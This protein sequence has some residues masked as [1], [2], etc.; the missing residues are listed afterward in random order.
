MRDLVIGIDASTTAVKAIAF[1]RTGQ[2]LAECRA[3]YPMHMPHPGHYEQNPQDWWQS[4]CAALKDL[5]AK[6]D[7]D[8]FA[9]IAV[10]HQRETFA[11]LDEAGKA[12]RPAIL[13]LDERA[14]AQVADLSRALGRKRIRDWSGKPPDPTP[15]L[16]A[17][18]WLSEHEPEALAC[19]AM[20]VDAGAYL[21]LRLTGNAVSATPSADPLGILNVQSKSWQPELVAAAG[22]APEQLPQLAAPAALIGEITAE[23]ARLTGLPEGLPVYAGAGDGQCNAL[24]LGACREG[25]ACFSLG[26]GV[27][28]GMHSGR[29]QSSDAFRTL[30]AASG[31]GYLLE[32]VLRSGMQLAD[33]VVRTTGAQSA[34][35]LE[36]AAFTVPAGSD[37][38][39]MLPYFAG[40]MSP[41]WDDAARGAVIGLSLSHQPK[42]LFRAAL[43]AI[44]FEQSLASDAMEAAVGVKAHTLIA[45]GGGANSRL[46]MTILAAVLQR[47]VAVSPVTEAAALGA[48]MLAATGAGWHSHAHDASDAMS[49]KAGQIVE[50]D[51]ALAAAYAPLNALYRDY[52]RTIQPLQAALANAQP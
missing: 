12:V 2:A 42:H 8:R 4:L 47:P 39:L 48:A 27:V 45:S 37:G 10:T 25:V 20:V 49:P 28:S 46:L 38:L 29:F 7:P 23:A 33:W 24:G 52:Y 34:P 44:S 41:F 36:R 35:D 3:A 19:A 5:T 16:Y 31:E 9:A 17:L 30:I 50:P 22:L 51:S 11:L 32:T 18:A 26:S 6:V 1:S 43:E 13:W 15:A 14:R 40:V 21:H